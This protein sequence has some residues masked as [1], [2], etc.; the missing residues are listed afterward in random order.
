VH[1]RVG[2]LVAMESVFLLLLQLAD[3]F[4]CSTNS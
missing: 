2:T 1:E 3:V 4:C